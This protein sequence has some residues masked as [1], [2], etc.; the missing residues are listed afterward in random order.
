MR[1]GIKPCPFGRCAAAVKLLENGHWIVVC[2]GEICAGRHAAEDR[3]SE[4]QRE[5]PQKGI[6]DE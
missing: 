1:N 6:N 4:D 3:E 5:K 2:G